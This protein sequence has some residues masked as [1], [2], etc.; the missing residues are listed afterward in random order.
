MTPQPARALLGALQLPDL[1]MTKTV[2]RVTAWRTLA[3]DPDTVIPR[4][5]ATHASFL[6]GEALQA[7]VAQARA[8]AGVA[9]ELGD[10][11]WTVTRWVEE[12]QP[13]PLPELAAWEDQSFHYI[14]NEG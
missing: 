9:H 12:I 13:M 7:A 14:P 10:Y 6:P 8:D 1:T 4:W 2:W 3:T 5:T 11:L